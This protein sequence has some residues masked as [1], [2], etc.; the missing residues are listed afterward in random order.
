MEW[1]WG[2][3]FDSA[4]LHAMPG[5]WYG[6]CL[7]NWQS[8]SPALVCAPVV[9]EFNRLPPGLGR[10]GPGQQ[11]RAQIMED[12]ILLVDRFS[13]LAY[14]EPS[15]CALLG[16]PDEN[17]VRQSWRHLRAR[18]GFPELISSS[19]QRHGRAHRGKGGPTLQPPL[20][21]EVT[22]T[23]LS[24]AAFS[25]YLI[26]M[27]GPSLT[28]ATTL[29]L[30]IQG[31]MRNQ[32]YLNDALV[33][34]L[35]APLNAM[36]IHLELLAENIYGATVEAGSV[37][38]NPHGL[39]TLKGVRILKDELARLNRILS[40]LL[41]G[42]RVSASGEPQYTQLNLVAA[43]QQ[44]V[45]LLAPKARQQGVKLNLCYAE[46][47]LMVRGNKDYL[48]Q[49][50]L[51]V[52]I[53]GLEAMPEGGRL[54]ISLR[55]IGGQVEVNFVDEGP[56]IA[57]DLLQHVCNLR[58]TTKPEGCG[59]GLYAARAVISQVH[60]GSLRVSNAEQ[61]GACVTCRLPGA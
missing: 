20:N 28:Q 35:R 40:T 43:M 12:G 56:G 24:T 46:P 53:N 25:G 44:L 32:D 15:V 47:S 50:F 22:L 11:L 57:P 41:E 55:R 9:T 6:L 33:H 23:P 61:G 13:E 49:A 58:F 4:G 60:L 51:N 21:L 7:G 17:A 29:Q 8:T 31:Q 26:R 14:V 27:R 3:G 36:E 16:C 1:A 38:P 52:A 42:G 18:L 34:D 54:T 37:A 30:L 2:S 48:R 45:L 39:Q 59:V 10:S 19:L 5:G